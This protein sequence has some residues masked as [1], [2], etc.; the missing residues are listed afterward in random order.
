MTKST[1]LRIQQQKPYIILIDAPWHSIVKKNAGKPSLNG[2]LFAVF[3]KNKKR[4]IGQIPRKPTQNCPQ[5]KTNYSHRFILG[6]AIEKK[7]QVRQKCYKYLFF[8]IS[9]KN[10]GPKSLNIDVAINWQQLFNPIKRMFHIGPH[11]V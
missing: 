2:W 6:L 11:V 4:T 10:T 1:L 3:S 8:L 9:G 5:S 7:K